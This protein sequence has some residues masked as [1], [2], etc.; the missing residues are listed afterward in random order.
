VVLLPVLWPANMPAFRVYA[1]P[2]FMESITYLCGQACLF[3][4]LRHTEASRLAPLLGFKVAILAA[5]S[6]LLFRYGITG[7]QWIAV[8]LAVAAA[9][10]LNEHGGR[11]PRSAVVAILLTCV[12]YATSDLFIR[13]TIDR[14]APVPRVQ[15]SLLNVAMSYSL[16]GVAVLPLW[17][18]AK[19]IQRG[20]VWRAT[21]YALTWLTSMGFL[22]ISF[23]YIGVVLG[24]IV[25]SSRGL[26]SILLGPLVARS[27][28]WGHLESTK[29]T[30]A[31]LRHAGIALLMVAAVV[32]YVLGQ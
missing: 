22:F 24:N 20:D 28:D 23:A 2:L 27:D 25:Q 19:P 16:C 10:L 9:W 26:I 3:T 17:W 29:P 31:V 12:F 4:A 30:H 18:R 8:A 11:L 21:P 7:Q 32:L 5:L 15:A 1:W 13:L 14:L 6:W